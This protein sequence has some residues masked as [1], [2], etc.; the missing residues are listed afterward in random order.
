MATPKDLIKAA[1]R[2]LVV[3]AEGEE[4][5]NEGL[6]DA[7]SE[8]NRMMAQWNNKNYLVLGT[9]I[10]EF[11]L[12][13]SQNS[14]TLGSGGNF[15]TTVPIRIDKVFIKYDSNTEIPIEIIDNNR[16]GE[17]VN[18]STE[19]NTPR[20]VF[21]DINHPL[22][23]LYFYP[24]PSEVKTII[25]HNFRQFSAFSTTT[26]SISLPNGYEDAIVYNLAMRL[27]PEYGKEPS[28]TIIKYAQD[29]LS[30]I[31]RSNIRPRTVKLDSALSGSGGFDYR[32]GG[33]D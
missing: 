22:M 26:E 12:V 1:L 13:A 28:G 15:N 29:A 23:K 7:F 2:K 18:K 16:W 8:L 10:E 6:T 32:T 4:P 9:N 27:A 30:D 5:S 3:L 19:S 14:Y 25:L 33:L 24:T 21:I 17:I 11:S 20:K 31:K